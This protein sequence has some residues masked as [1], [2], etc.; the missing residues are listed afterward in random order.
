MI[1]ERRPGRRPVK[2]GAF[3]REARGTRG[4]NILIDIIYIYIDTQQHTAVT[5]AGTAVCCYTL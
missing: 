4:P 2:I 3:A 1:S 5:A